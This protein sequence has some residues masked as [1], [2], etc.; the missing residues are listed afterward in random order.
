MEKSGYV[1]GIFFRNMQINSI[2]IAT[3]GNAHHFGLVTGYILFWKSSSPLV[4]S[5]CQSTINMMLK[6]SIRSQ[7]SRFEVCFGEK[8]KNEC[9]WTEFYWGI[10]HWP[11]SQY[12]IAM[13]SA[14]IY[15]SCSRWWCLVEQQEMSKPHECQ[16]IHKI[17]KTEATQYKR[18]QCDYLDYFDV[19]KH[20][21]WFEI[22]QSWVKGWFLNN[23]CHTDV[24]MIA[25]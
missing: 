24:D 9:W 10:Y 20:D 7:T 16:Q 2:N 3:S 23:R 4:I 5:M 19:L 8:K 21:R 18:D 13:V 25:A 12:C 14:I 22:S 17:I 11:R 6:K 1:R 15:P